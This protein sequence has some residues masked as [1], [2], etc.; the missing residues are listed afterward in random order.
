MAYDPQWQTA[1]I[2]FA[3]GLQTKMADA[4]IPV[5]ALSVL[6]NG[7]F[8]KQG[9]VK[10]RAGYSEIPSYTATG[11]LDGNSRGLLAWGDSLALVTDNCIYSQD[12]HG[13]WSN[14]GRYLATTY[15]DR[16]VAYANKNQT[17]AD[18]A[19]TNGVACVVWKYA[20][21]SL[22]FQCFDSE[23]YAPLCAATV[24]ASANADHPSAI[25]I[26]DTIL[27]CY[28]N[29]STNA[30]DARLIQTG[31]LQA[32]VATAS[33][34]T[35][36]SDLA[37]TRRWAI[38]AGAPGEAYLAWEAD[39]S[40][41]T[42]T[43][44]TGICLAAFNQAGGILRTAIVAAATV[45]TCPPG[46]FYNEF[47]GVVLVAWTLAS[48]HGYREYTGTTMSAVA[49]AVDLGDQ[50]DRVACGPDVAMFETSNTS[51]SSVKLYRVTQ[52]LATTVRHAHLAS[53]GFY[54][55]EIPCVMLA[56]QSQSGIQNSYYL[57]SYLGE[58]LGAM[59]QSIANDRVSSHELPHYSNGYM[60]LGFKRQLS[61]DNFVAQYA[62]TGIRLVTFDT[63]GAVS[64]AE[65][66]NSSYASG[67]Q[68]W[69]YDGDGTFEAG[70]HMF[71]D[72][73]AGGTCTAGDG[74][75]IG[76]FT[77][78]AAGSNLTDATQYNYR[79]YYEWYAAN[80]ELIRSAYMQR[81]VTTSIASCRM[82][83]VIP[84]LRHTLKSVTHSKAAE[85]SIVV[86]RDSGNSGGL[87]FFRVSSP[88]PSTA[89]A[90]N[91]YLANSFS[92]DTVTFVDDIADGTAS[93]QLETF[94]RDYGS[95]AILINAPIP[96]PE[97]VVANA[98][99][100]FIAGGGVPRGVVLPSKT[101]QPETSAG[102]STELQLTPVGDDVTG[103][104]SVNGAV[105]V[106]TED[107]I[108]AAP[109]PGQDNTGGGPPYVPERVTTDVG[110]ISGASVVEF[111]Q[112]LMFQSSKGIYALGQDFDVGYIGAPVER[113]NDQDI[114]GAHVIPDTNQVVF[115]SSEGTTLMYDYLYGQ[116]GTFKHHEGL[117]AQRYDN[118]Y[119]YVR[120]D[121]AVWVR[122]P[123]AYTDAG[124]PII[125]RVRTGRFR[126]QG[127]QAWFKLRTVSV[128]GEY[129]SPHDLRV[130]LFYDRE[131]SY[132]EERVFDVE[133]I[134]PIDDFGDG[135]PFGDEDWFGGTNGRQDYNFMIDSRRMK[136][137]QFAIE[138]SDIISESAGASFEL[139]ELLIEFSVQRG[140][141]RMPAMR[142]G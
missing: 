44:D 118:D 93:G 65:H 104:A 49:S 61:I 35:I 78:R 88:D 53:H 56:H 82:E 103:L 40:V 55:Y 36:A 113:Y 46:V 128:L 139:T 81:A 42:A 66:G 94:E 110:C 29:T 3:V 47:T 20:T 59:F 45:P 32:S 87:V 116:W 67:C 50:V 126:P 91:G 51:N 68:L 86:Y 39:G 132:S 97:L 63:T 18:V 99:R 21:N 79:F 117:A 90:T 109:G 83:I 92:A 131:T 106:F 134:L 140:P 64:S 84:T 37:A 2:P 57:Y 101:Y 27:L 129:K 98:D 73:A 24:L 17:A 127:L 58:C 125:L 13:L 41:S 19:V 54:Q 28:S 76:P 123:D 69:Q 124:S 71:P 122:T 30:V 105:V 141:N 121:G 22:Y 48:F 137:S 77:Q 102:F 70:F 60:A 119:V 75:T 130:R 96:G 31:T 7:V 111:P 8:T 1:S 52:S 38:C 4:A 25:A 72:V 135:D 95:E 136:C 138:F 9:S 11:T 89:G 5:E 14:R 107:E 100:L 114:T 112:G 133:A 108:Y 120:N 23:T 12:D 43:R 115:L 10:K 62:H 34:V 15:R 16:E 74:G 6:E 33:V 26:N 85:V 142:K 80:G